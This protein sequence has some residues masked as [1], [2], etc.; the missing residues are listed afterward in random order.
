MKRICGHFPVLQCSGGN[1][2]GALHAVRGVV[3]PI[4][5]RENYDSE[6]QGSRAGVVARSLC[7]ILGS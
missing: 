3:I 2:A 5:A 6:Q 1:V 4:H 7:Q